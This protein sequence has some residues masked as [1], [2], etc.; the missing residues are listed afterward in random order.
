MTAKFTNW[1]AVREPLAEVLSAHLD[2]IPEG[3]LDALVLTVRDYARRPSE[4][5]PAAYTDPGF[6]KDFA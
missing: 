4:L 1:D 6:W 2:E 3:L 5:P